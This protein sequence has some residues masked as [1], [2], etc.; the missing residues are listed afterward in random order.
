MI[1]HSEPLDPELFTPLLEAYMRYKLPVYS[2]RKNSGRGISQSMGILPRRNY[3]VGE[4]R[5]N[6]SYP[7][8]LRE[9]RKLAAIICPDLNYTTLAINIDYTALPHKDKNNDGESCVVAFNKFEGGK[10]VANNIEY[11][12]RHRPFRFHASETLHSV[13]AIHGGTRFSIVW[14]RPR[15]PRAFVARYGSSLSY[16]ELLALIPVREPGQPASAVRI[17]V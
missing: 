9:A 14:F 3:G 7:D 6:D 16:D 1:R 10:L 15:F 5:N 11:D 17:P 8:I 4:S 2:E 13:G 12:I